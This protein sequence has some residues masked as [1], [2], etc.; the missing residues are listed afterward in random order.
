MNMIPRNL[1][2]LL[3]IAGC[4][5]IVSPVSLMAGK[6]VHPPPPPA[7]PKMRIQF[8]DVPN[9]D[10]EKY[11]VQ[12]NNFGQVVGHYETAAGERHGFLYDPVVNPEVALDLNDLVDAPEGWVIAGA[13]AINDYGAVAGFLHPVGDETVSRAFV[14]DL[15]DPTPFVQTLPDSEWTSTLALGINENGDVLGKFRNAD[16]TYGLYVYNCGLYGRADPGVIVLSTNM[17][18]GGAINNPVGTRG[19]QV[20]GQDA[21]TGVPFR[22]TRGQGF[23]FLTQAGTCGVYDINDAGT[24]CGWA[25]FK[26]SKT[27]YAKLPMRYGTLLQSLPGGYSTELASRVNASG[28]VITTWGRL[29]SDLWGFKTLNTLIDPADPNAAA[30]NSRSNLLPLTLN[31]RGATTKCGQVSGTIWWAD[32]TEKFFLLTPVPAQ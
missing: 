18:Y 14:C 17:I 9:P 13:R 11:I 10:G 16:G 8:F 7:V 29:Y 23:E 19:A 22:W 26:I 25:A 31:D 30:W 28:D 5:L 3:T 20:L 4:A 12:M 32:G 1:L 6:P 21:V 27:S 2:A 24:F 15:S